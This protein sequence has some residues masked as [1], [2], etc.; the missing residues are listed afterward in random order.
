MLSQPFAELL[1]LVRTGQLR[2]I[3]GQSYPLTAVRQ[4]HEDLRARR[5]TGKVVLLPHAG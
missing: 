1:E 4:A 2:P 5:T 3:V